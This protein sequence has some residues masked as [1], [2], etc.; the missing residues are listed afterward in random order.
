MPQPL[1]K[2]SKAI[3]TTFL[4]LPREIRQKILLQSNPFRLPGLNVLKN[5]LDTHEFE[6]DSFSLDFYSH[7]CVLWAA[8]VRKINQITD[9]VDYVEQ[10]WLKEVMSLSQKWDVKEALRATAKRLEELSIAL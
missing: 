6:R 4:T 1:P 3:K 7:G 5:K 8:S 10:L 2:S 9:D